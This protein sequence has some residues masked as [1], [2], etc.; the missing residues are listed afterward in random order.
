MNE[1][2]EME[3]PLSGAR[4]RPP[5][6]RDLRFGRFRPGMIFL[7]V[8]V[9]SLLTGVGKAP[10]EVAPAELYNQANALYREGKYK[11]AIERYKAVLKQGVENGAV[12]YN[13]GNAYYKSGN[14]GRAILNYER[15]LRLMPGDPDVRANLRFVDAKK[16][17]KESPPDQNVLTRFLAHLYDV[18]PAN[19]LAVFCSLCLFLL[20]GVG[21][22]WLY[23]PGRRLLWATLLVLLGF[24]LCGSGSVLAFKIHDREAVR[25]AVILS[26]EAVGRSGPGENYI[27]VF[28]LHEGTQV[29]IERSESDWV[30]VRLPSGIGGWVPQGALEVI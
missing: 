29:D 13:L 30:L 20:A 18:L 1:S 16:V 27:Q 26:K 15:A 25:E 10:A 21:I 6:E 28:T 17:D 7:L 5:T 22:A 8:L 14:L 3:K 23:Q 2:R 24:G 9:A 19:E 11:D 4:R 12:Y